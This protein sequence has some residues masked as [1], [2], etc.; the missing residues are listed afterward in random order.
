MK[1]SLPKNLIILICISFFGTMEAQKIQGNVYDYKDRPID[2]VSVFHGSEKISETNKDG[3]FFL[4]GNYSFPIQLRLEHPNYYLKHVVMGGNY[5]SFRLSLLSTEENLDEIVVTSSDSKNN[6]LQ[7]IDDHI[8]PIENISSKKLETFSPLDLVSA[9]NETPGV[10]IHSGAL[11]TNR[12]TVR[13]VGSRTLYGTNKI[14]AYF[15]DI[16]ITDGSGETVIDMFDPENLNSIQII[17]GPKATH[18]GTN[19]GGTILL[20][21]KQ[22]KVGESFLKSNLTLGSYG[23]IK[24]TVSMAT[25]SENWILNLNYDHLE[26]EGYRENN[27]YNRKAVVLTSSY[28]FDSGNELS[29]LFNYVDYFAQIPSSIGKT[30]FEEDPSQAAYTWK[31]AQGFES[32]KKI[33]TGLDYTHHFSTKF[34]NTSSVFYTYLDHYEPRPFDILDEFTNG[35][36]ARTV[37][38]TD[39]KFLKTTGSFSFGGEFYQDQYDWKTIEN[40]Y[41]Q[42]EGN[43]SLEGNLLSDNREKRNNLNVFALASISFTKKLKGQFGLNFNKTNYRNQNLYNLGANSKSGERTF[44]HI[45]APNIN[46]GYHFSET[47]SS[48]LNFSRGFNFP[49]IEETLTPEGDINPDL[50]P[51][52]GYNYEIGSNLVL[53]QKRLRLQLNLYLM[54]IN[55][56]LVAQRVGDDQYVGRNA[57][58]TEHKGVELNLS[59]IQPINQDLN[60]SSYV[61]AEITNHRFIDFVDGDANY[62]GNKLTGVPNQKFNG[63]IGMEYKGFHLNTNFLHIGKIPLNDSN[64]LFSESYTIFNFKA[65]F[66][67]EFSKMISAEINAGINN[68]SNERYASSILINATGFGNSEPRYYYPGMPRNW[69]SGIQLKFHL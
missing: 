56:L 37:F 57:G 68:L 65:S 2:H 54:D 6:L 60:I 12:I 5:Q 36:G 26:T 9:I 29:L 24:N 49:S 59:F 38:E 51:E 34:R 50:G 17:K 13:G 66:R 32:N 22:P 8:I 16:P 44:K 46:L 67:K 1:Y 20:H 28:R 47:F 61:N 31:E 52:K 23:M 27:S 41:Q 30:D 15:N 39:F 63:G 11:N 53:L 25:A 33:I 43:G 64:S 7:S 55:D 48:Y 42:N 21:S 45:I 69:F 62:S 35:Y 4:Q 10:F 58:K 14:R 40:L 3:I 19:L 18:Y